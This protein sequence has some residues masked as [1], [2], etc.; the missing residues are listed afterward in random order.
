[1]GFELLNKTTNFTILR[2][3]RINQSKEGHGIQKD[4]ACFS[5]LIK[6]EGKSVFKHKN[7][8]YIADNSNILFIPKGVT[9]N[10]K[11]AEKGELLMIDFDVQTSEEFLSFEVF[12]VKNQME[13]IKLFNRMEIDWTFKKDMYNLKCLIS[14]YEFIVKLSKLYNNLYIPT[15]KKKII[16]PSIKYLENN[17]HNP[18]ISNDSLAA[19]SNIS[20]VYFRKLFTEIFGISPMKYVQNIRISKAKDLLR[21]EFVS[22]SEIANDVG[23]SSIYHFS[24]VFKQETGY[25]P[26]EF[27]KLRHDK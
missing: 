20:V 12:N 3:N 8:E 11:C 17:F 2:V 23:F 10:W 14:L 1:M 25:S 26:T 21:G 16:M 13:Y 18:K 15:A 4:R 22:I 19:L 27:M 7:K 5:F 6:T 9:Y 24:K